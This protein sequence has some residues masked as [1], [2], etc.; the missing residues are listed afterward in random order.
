MPFW[1]VLHKSQRVV[2]A[3]KSHSDRYK[4]KID[5]IKLAGGAC[6]QRRY[7]PRRT[8]HKSDTIFDK[9]NPVTHLKYLRDRFWDWDFPLDFRLD[10]QS[11]ITYTRPVSLLFLLTSEHR[12][13]YWKQ[14]LLGAQGR[15]QT[16]SA[17][18]LTHAGGHEI[19]V[20]TDMCSICLTV[21]TFHKNRL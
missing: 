9:H 5:D 8:A 6:W 4:F 12:L 17:G 10:F 21:F 16:L 11:N 15:I 14:T 20:H 2:S 19:Y 1:C 18:A 13:F 7:V 3:G